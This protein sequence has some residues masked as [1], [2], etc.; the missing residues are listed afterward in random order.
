MYTYFTTE[1]SLASKL[2][3]KPR[4]PFYKF[5]SHVY[6]SF[7]AAGHLSA[8]LFLV[9]VRGPPTT[10]TNNTHAKTTT[11]IQALATSLHLWADMHEREVTRD[12]VLAVCSAID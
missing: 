12:V 7:S 1:T 5:I 6:L 10:C 9:E 8:K 2:L 4:P 11:F 3:L